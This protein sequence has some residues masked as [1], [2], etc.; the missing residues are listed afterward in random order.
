M[1]PGF[2]L[3]FLKKKCFVYLKARKEISLFK[4]AH[5]CEKKKKKVLFR[6]PHFLLALIF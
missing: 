6:T 2:F 1:I 3:F 4:L 5:K